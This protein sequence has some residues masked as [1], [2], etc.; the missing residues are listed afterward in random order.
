MSTERNGV[1]ISNIIFV[2]ISLFTQ[3]LKC[4]FLVEPI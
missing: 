3:G 1:E 2:L 4:V